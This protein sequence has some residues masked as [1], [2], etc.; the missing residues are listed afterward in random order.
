MSDLV[1]NLED[2]F[3]H[4]AAQTAVCEIYYFGLLTCEEIDPPCDWAVFTVELM[5]S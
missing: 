1:G 5:G 4:D 3:S 2:M